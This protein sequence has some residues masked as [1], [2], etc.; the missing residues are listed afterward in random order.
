MQPTF[1]AAIDSWPFVGPTMGK[2]VVF[3]EKS[4][5]FVV[6]KIA[7]TY[8]VC[9]DR[10]ANYRGGSDDGVTLKTESEVI[11]YMENNE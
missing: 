4:G 6:T 1:K 11:E 3:F 8:W 5:H 7:D 9:D 2:P 10:K